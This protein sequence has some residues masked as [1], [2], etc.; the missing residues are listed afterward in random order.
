[1]IAATS[2]KRFFREPVALPPWHWRKN[3][4][5]SRAQREFVKDMVH[6]LI[7]LQG[8]FGSGK[9][10][11]LGH[12]T[13]ALARRNPGLT[14]GV[15][16]PSFPAL[17]QD[18][19]PA[20]KGLLDAGKLRHTEN[21]QEMWIRVEAWGS[22]I[23][24][25]TA[26]KPETLKGPNWAWAC[27]NEPGIWPREV[28]ELLLS[29]VRVRERDT[30]INQIAL[31]GT[32]EGFGWLHAETVG[33][34][35]DAV[36][37]GTCPECRVI[38]ASTRQATWLA[39]RYLAKLLGTYSAAM[40]REKVDGIATLLGSGAYAAFN[41]SLHVL[42]PAAAEA[43]V[44]SGRAPLILALDFNIA[45]AIALTLLRLPHPSF[46]Q[47]TY[48][49][50]EIA[51]E[52]GTTAEVVREWRR[53]WGARAKRDGLQVIGDATGQS[54]HATGAQCY[55]EVWRALRTTDGS[56]DD[57]V[58]ER[59]A[60]SE[61]SDRTPSSNPPVTDRIAVVNGALE[62]GRL[63]VHPQCVETIADL[64]QC[65]YLPGTRELDKRDKKRT[66][67]TD[68]LGYDQHNVH[69]ITDLAAV[70]AVTTREARPWD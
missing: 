7:V 21:R 38:L 14:G 6:E 64:E 50:D 46:G 42:T 28:W 16:G 11:A 56:G 34:Y 32:P 48:V 44:F 66:H 18:M 20:I 30:D 8:G 47:V 63:H 58:A 36:Y 5:P 70:R 19:L 17:K 49:L 61:W 69:A 23:K 37:A 24:F 68:A 59:T 13:L 27:G 9:S 12:K 40:V 22:T 52:R 2:R 15:V 1:M 60:V 43:I 53:R 39:P 41:R 55:E 57:G 33:R 65:R 10:H 26:D 25:A 29:R 35:G 62:H 45:P 3:A 4:R 51:L 31:A 67:W 54:Q